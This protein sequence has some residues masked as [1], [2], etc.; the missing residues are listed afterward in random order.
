MY[1][2]KQAALRSGVSVTLLRAW[3]RRYGV[4]EPARTPS[5]YRLYDERAISRLRAMRALVRDGWTPSNAAARV[6]GADESVLAELA[7]PADRDAGRLYGPNPPNALDAADSAPRG[8]ELP[9]PLSLDASAE[10]ID[11]FV[12]AA[13]ALDEPALEA[14][15]DEMF[16]RGSFEHV[17]TGTL[18]PAL[19]E[20]GERWAAGRL[21]IAAEHAAAASVMRRL[22]SA[23][24]AAGRPANGGDV[25]LVGLP[26]GARHELGALAFAT[27]ARRSGLNVRY[28][29]A[30]LPV[31]SWV[32]AAVRTSAGAAAIGAVIKQDRQPS[33]QVAMALLATRP[34][35][36]ICFG[37]RMAGSIE[38]A[39]PNE[40]R[41]PE[42][43][44]EAVEA[45]RAAIAD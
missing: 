10:L 16:A 6:L 33:R 7:A 42:G 41:L 32:N 19:V 31:E 30:D 11:H 5:G 40:L 36:R 14:V 26:P 45:L 37:G 28:L 25:V 44:V 24:I 34:S 27:A 1:T 38:S 9:G 43:I 17:T 15:L 21:G 12:E 13:A 39:H 4:V 8:G 18:M 3:E 23:F 20:V 22:G 35:M 29:G 2:I